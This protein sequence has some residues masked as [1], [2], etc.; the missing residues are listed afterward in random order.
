MKLKYILYVAVLGL[1]FACEPEL[2]DFD[3]NQGSADFSTYISLGNSL[4]AGYASGSLYRSGQLNSYPSILA[5]QFQKVGGGN[6]VQPLLDGEYGILPG[7]RALGYSTDCLGTTSL[8]PVL[9]NG[10]LDPIAPIGYTVN[11]LGVPGAKSFH[12]LAPGYG[13]F[14]GL[15]LGLS[16][17]YYA[18]FASSETAT[19][20]G[21]AVAM[22]ATFFTLWIGNNDVLGYATSGGIG[23]TITGQDTYAFAVNT[24]LNYLTGNG[25]KGAIATI[26]FVTS[27]PFF[28]TVPYNA[29]VLTQQAQVDALNNAYQNGQFGVSFN[30]GPN[31][32]VIADNT[33]PTG[34]RQVKATELVLLTV[35]QDS[36]KCAGWGSQ[37][38]IPD[39]YVLTE[40]EIAKVTNAVNGYNVL[41]KS[42]AGSYGLALVDMNAYLEEIKGGV[43]YDGE[44]FSGKFITG[45]AFSLD[46]V[47]LTQKGYALVANKFIEAINAKYGSNVPVV[48]TT[49]Y[50]ANILP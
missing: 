47:H 26:P 15:P 43:V 31:P 3:Y 22:N 19:V 50:Q 49:S 27:I 17:P 41:L 44:S 5:Q 34:F 42:L 40:T 21:D 14:A 24:I 13:S 33:L 12:L 30:L 25:A 46:G 20:I 23:D 10:T 37:V 11:N 7:K 6:F 4:T 29:L 36:I 16:N 48:S 8:G 18:R 1:L 38:P 32:L 2:K 45:N 9:D 28:T 39:Q 35:P